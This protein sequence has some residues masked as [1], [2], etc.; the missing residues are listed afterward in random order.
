[1]LVSGG[2]DERGAPLHLVKILPLGSF[3]APPADPSR[4]R[5]CVF[6]SVC[7]HVVEHPA[8]PQHVPWLHAEL[9]SKGAV[10]P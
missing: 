6:L 3:H 1:M 2:G 10:C 4:K 9:K 8:E 5:V 7:V